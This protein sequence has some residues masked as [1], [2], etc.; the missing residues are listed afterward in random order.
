MAAP[1]LADGTNQFADEKSRVSYA[2]GLN[3]GHNFKQQGLDVDADVVGRAIKDVLTGGS[4]L[5]TEAQAKETLQTF[6]KDF[7]T[8]LLAKN[9]AD[10]DAFL[11]GNKNQPGVNVLPDGLQYLVLTN[12][13][14]AI[15]TASDTVTVNYRGTLLDGTEFDSSYKRGQPASFQVGGVI[16]GWT[17]ALQ[18]MPVGSKWKLFIPSE[19][20]YGEP[21]NRGIPPNSTLIFEVELLGIQAAT[22]PPA[23]APVAPL[24]SD[25]IKVPS[26]EELKKGAKIEVIKPEDVQKAQA[27]QK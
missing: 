5:L 3:I 1:L 24:T 4:E 6:Q 16:H 13:T 12:G 25:I 7:R 19:L 9:K 18:K 8:R 15:P 21:G 27:Q 14:G 20:A 10:G 11:A 22:P 2:I 23:P 26:A 17:E